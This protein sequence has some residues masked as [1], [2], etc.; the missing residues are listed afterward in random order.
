MVANPSLFS[1]SR[2]TSENLISRDKLS[3]PNLVPATHWITPS[4]RDGIHI[5]RQTPS[6][7]S[8][9]Y[10]VKQLRTDGVRCRESIGTRPVASFNVVGVTGAVF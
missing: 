6:G 2:F 3:R 9:V 7:Q 8:R 5:Y 10:G 1:L 4:F